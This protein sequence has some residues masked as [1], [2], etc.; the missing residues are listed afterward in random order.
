MVQVRR[1]ECM[2]KSFGGLRTE[3]FPCMSNFVQA[4]ECF[5]AKLANMD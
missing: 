4:I 1:D 3:E 5:T 2:D